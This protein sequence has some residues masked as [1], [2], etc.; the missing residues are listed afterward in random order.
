MSD[1]LATI[2]FTMCGLFFITVGLFIILNGIITHRRCEEHADGI[3]VSTLSD[4]SRDKDDTAH[5]S[6]KYPI[7]RWTLEDGSTIEQKYNGHFKQWSIG[8]EV[9]LSY[10]PNDPTRFFI[11]RDWNK[12]MGSIYFMGLGVAIVLLPSIVTMST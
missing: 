12:W 9:Q 11:H 5:G 4:R 3:I 1:K 8:D 7:V 6:A 2:P 10:D